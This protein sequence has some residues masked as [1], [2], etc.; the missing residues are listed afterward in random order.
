MW[1]STHQALPGGWVLLHADRGVGYQGLLLLLHFAENV[2]IL[3]P[4]RARWV[5]MHAEAWDR[6]VGYQGRTGRRQ[7]AGVR[8]SFCAQLCKGQTGAGEGCAQWACS[9]ILWACACRNLL[10]Q[11]WG[12]KWGSRLYGQEM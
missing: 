2:G 9:F 1:A 4:G 5:L 10:K 3:S 11:S 8:L 6:D 7:M 12:S